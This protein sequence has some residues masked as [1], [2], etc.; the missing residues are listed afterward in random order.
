M[1]PAVIGRQAKQF[2]V[3]LIVVIILSGRRLNASVDLTMIT[4]EV[5]IGCGSGGLDH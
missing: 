4:F 3:M 1:K 5:I 2:E